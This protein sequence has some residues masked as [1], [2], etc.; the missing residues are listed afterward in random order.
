[1]GVTNTHALIVIEDKEAITRIRLVRQ[2]CFL[3]HDEILAGRDRPKAIATAARKASR[4]APVC[5]APAKRYMMHAR[6]YVIGIF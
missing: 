5:I 4:L 3:F 6:G 2:R 1:M